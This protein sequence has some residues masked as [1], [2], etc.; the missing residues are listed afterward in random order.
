MDQIVSILKHSQEF[1]DFKGP[2]KLR[3]QDQP[4]VRA[5]PKV[6]Q[7]NELLNEAKF[8]LSANKFLGFI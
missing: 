5:E 4:V 6:S 7:F 1:Q 3:V 8:L 2:G